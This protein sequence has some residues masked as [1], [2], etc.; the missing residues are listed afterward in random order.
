[1]AKNDSGPKPSARKRGLFIGQNGTNL[2]RVT[3]V[4]KPLRRSL[5]Q[6]FAPLDRRSRLGRDSDEFRQQLIMHC[7][8]NP[9]ATQMALIRLACQL[10]LRITIMDAQFVE[11]GQPNGC[12][13]KHYLAWVNSLARTVAKLGMRGTPAP[14]TTLADLLESESSGKTTHTSSATGRTRAPV[15]PAHRPRRASGADPGNGPRATPARRP[16]P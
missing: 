9:S 14:Q 2:L 3:P 6:D 1:M 12:D 7:G 8:G 16:V 11:G 5:A 15:Q 10:W 13:S 4:T